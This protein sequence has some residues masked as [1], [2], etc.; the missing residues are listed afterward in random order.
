MTKSL[1]NNDCCRISVWDIMN[2]L[3]W[4]QF[5]SVWFLLLLMLTIFFLF[6]ILCLCLWPFP[7]PMQYFLKL[8]VSNHQKWLSIQNGINFS[9]VRP[10]RFLC[11]HT[12]THMLTYTH[13]SAN[14]RQC[15]PIPLL[16][17]SEQV[18]TRWVKKGHGEKCSQSLSI[19][20]PTS[21]LEATLKG[22][23]FHGV[24]AKGHFGRLPAVMAHTH[25]DLLSS[26][27]IFM[28][29]RPVGIRESLAWGASQRTG[30][31]S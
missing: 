24:C 17:V 6:P 12:H 26:S 29:G 13:G 18:A 14:S 31:D 10:S 4:R 22:Q 3:S 2:D 7:H 15:K 21:F 11:A 1:L 19:N 28:A 9:L 27:T 5:E 25:I 30:V 8:N 23:F 16:P 20:P